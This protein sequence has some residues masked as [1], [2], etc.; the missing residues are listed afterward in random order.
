LATGIQDKFSWKN[1]ALSALSAGVGAGVGQIAG[2]AAKGFAAGA[3]RGALGNAITQGVSVVTGLQDKFDWTGVAVGAVVGGTVSA[4]GSR[5]APAP[6]RS[7]AAYG[8][9]LATG[10]AAAT[11]GATTRRLI[12]GT[13]FGDNILA[14]LPDVI[15]STIGNLVAGGIASGAPRAGKDIAPLTRGGDRGIALRNAPDLISVG[16]VDTSS[17]MRGVPNLTTAAQMQAV[18]NASRRTVA[19]PAVLID[20]NADSTRTYS[21]AT[22]AWDGDDIV[23]T[24][25]PGERAL[26]PAGGFAM[27]FTSLTGVSTASLLQREAPSYPWLTNHQAFAYGNRDYTS[28]AAAQ[29]DNPGMQGIG[30]SPSSADIA[31]GQIITRNRTFAQANGSMIAA[32]AYYNNGTADQISAGARL[33]GM[34]LDMAGARTIRGNIPQPSPIYR[35]SYFVEGPLVAGGLSAGR[36]SYAFSSAVSPGQKGSLGELAA[37]ATMARAGYKIRPSQLES[38]K[39]IDRV[40]VKYGSNGNP[41]DI[42]IN[43]SKFAIGRARYGDTTSMGDQMSRGWIDGNVAKMRVSADPQVRATGR[44]LEEN[45]GLVR[46]KTNVL[47]GQ[48]VNRWNVLDPYGVKNPLPY[49]PSP[50]KVG[51]Q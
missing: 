13:G 7:M 4:V 32:Y 29:R 19:T 2:I 40:F 45:R 47:N 43:E 3:A 17:L 6:A 10:A 22:S 34:A 12:T 14:T 38:G 35:P 37:D 51:G 44:L 36:Y 21:N 5:F 26:V 46:L 30:G 15:G 28:F 23:I 1:V 24:A 18:V 50:Y 31:L 48:G 27:D 41:I 8:Q 25:K 49:Q 33:G 16:T 39:G 42:I 9:Q 20:A 11:A